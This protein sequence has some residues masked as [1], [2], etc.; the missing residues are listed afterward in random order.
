MFVFLNLLFSTLVSFYKCHKN[1]FY[2]RKNRKQNL[3]AQISPKNIFLVQNWNNE[4]YHGIQHIWII[5]VLSLSHCLCMISQ[6]TKPIFNNFEFLDQIDSIRV[7]LFQNSTNEH[8]HQI[9]HIWISLEA[10]FY[11]KQ[12]ILSFWTKFTQKVYFPSKTGQININGELA[13]SN[14]SRCQILS[15]LLNR[16]FLFF[17]PNLPQNCISR[18]N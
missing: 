6:S 17:G 11:L 3:S 15:Y 1:L 2:F 12:R 5:Q 10:K 16:Q 4:R 9:Q 18:P 14:Y 13:Y 8:H 7:F